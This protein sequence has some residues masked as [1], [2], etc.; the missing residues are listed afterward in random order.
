M[1]YPWSCKPR[2]HLGE[3]TAHPFVPPSTFPKLCCKQG[4]A[5]QG[6]NVNHQDRYAPMP[7]CPTSD[8]RTPAVR[9]QTPIQCFSM[10]F[11][12]SSVAAAA[13]AAGSMVEY[14]VG[15]KKRG[16]RSGPQGAADATLSLRRYPLGYD[17]LA[18][19]CV[20]RN[21][22]T[23]LHHAAYH[24]H[25]KAVEVLIGA[26]AA[27]NVKTPKSYGSGRW[28]LLGAGAASAGRW[29]TASVPAGAPRFTAL[30]KKA[31]STRWLR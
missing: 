4:L 16:L 9:S 14:A 19:P 15:L 13:R 20:H 5:R 10:L 30:P 28:A 12:A 2:P 6:G 31:P 8:F 11:H 3:S 26:G 21:G 1:K 22:W 27:L 24:N 7:A 17:P 18:Q 29:P 25:R 23:A